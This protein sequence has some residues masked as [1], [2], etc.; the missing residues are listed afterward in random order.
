MYG[1]SVNEPLPYDEISFEKQF[2]S[3]EILITPVD[4]E[5]G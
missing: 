2:C 4:Y 5:F 1:H 3:N